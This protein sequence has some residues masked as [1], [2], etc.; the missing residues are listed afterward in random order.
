MEDV[1]IQDN[2]P[3]E[4]KEEFIEQNGV[5]VYMKRRGRFGHIFLSVDNT[6]LPEKYSGAYT[7]FEAARQDIYKY[8]SDRKLAEDKVKNNK[9]K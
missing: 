9:A 8:L 2:K 4:A 5:K 1:K 3:N 6:T 7:T